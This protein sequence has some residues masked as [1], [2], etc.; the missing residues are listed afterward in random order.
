MK[1]INQL[2][3]VDKFYQQT[4]DYEYISKNSLFMGL[5]CADSWPAMCYAHGIYAVPTLFAITEQLQYI[6]KFKTR[7]PC[8]VLE[9]GSG[10]GDLSCSL[11]YL[12][13]EV[14]S[15]E[16]NSL[17]AHFHRATYRHHFNQRPFDNY[18]LYM[19]DLNG[20]VKFLP[21]TIDT[22]ILVETIEHIDST[23]WSDF[24]KKVC[25]ILSAN[26][27]RLIITNLKNYWPLGCGTDT[28]PEHIAAIDDSFYDALEKTARKT[29][30]RENSHIVLEY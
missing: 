18:N 6:D 23:E 29:L 28:C 3:S 30:Y 10:P 25:P 4:Y 12:G 17:A 19:A 26:C 8:T 22:I 20:F 14:H 15:V 11:N 21:T 27:A 9:I 16:C 24:Y 13:Y 5:N 7:T 2:T 1:I